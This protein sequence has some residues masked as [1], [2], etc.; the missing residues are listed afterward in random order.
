MSS[1]IIHFLIPLLIVLGVFRYPT[2]TAWAWVWVGVAPDLDYA[3]WI[4]YVNH[5]WVNL[6]RALFHNVWLL[7]GLIGLA[8]WGFRR[9]AAKGPRT[10]GEFTRTQ[11]GWVLAPFY[12]FTHLALDVFAGGIVPFWP[13]SNMGVYWDFSLIV[14]TRKP[15]PVPEPISNPGTYTNIPIVVEI[16][17]WVNAEQFALLLLYLTAVFLGFVY[18]LRKDWRFT[19]PKAEASLAKRSRERASRRRRSG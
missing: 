10:L 9:A 7:F 3:S 2:K 16:Y 17:E 12:Y 13:V 6:H 8:V 11:P 15:I 4:L 5:G 1:V 14:D 19:L 18:Q